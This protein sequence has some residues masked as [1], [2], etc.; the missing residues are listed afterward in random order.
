MILRVEELIKKYD[1]KPHLEGG[2]FKEQYRSEQKLFS[3]KSGEERNAVTHI[4]FLLEKDQFSRFHKVL[5]DEIWNVYEGDPLKLIEFNGDKINEVIIG[6]SCEEYC[7]IIKGGLF[8]AAETTGE[9]TLVGCSVA[10]GFDFKDFSFIDSNPVFK[11][12]LEKYYP[13]YSYLI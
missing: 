10:P 4:Y 9:Y 7:H 3:P 12:T 2:Y 5:H 1:L 8:Q 6:A 13:T 11:E